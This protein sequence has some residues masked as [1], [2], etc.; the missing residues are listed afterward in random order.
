MNLKWQVRLQWV[1]LLLVIALAA[2]P[3]SRQIDIQSA[4]GKSQITIKPEGIWITRNN[5]TSPSTGCVLTATKN[6]G[7]LRLFIPE[8]G[9]F[10]GTD[11]R[12]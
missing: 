7:Q 6:G 4:D 3:A 10:T 12:W 5:D 8:T 1:V 11:P 2:A 9:T